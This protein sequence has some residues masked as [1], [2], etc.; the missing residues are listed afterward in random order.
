MSE[1]AETKIT[2]LE[3]VIQEQQ[4]ELIGVQEMLALVLKAVGQDVYVTRET[5][6]EGL[7]AGTQIKVE[8]DFQRNAFVFG[9]EYPDE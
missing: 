1:A 9:L 3:E 5:I 2:E 8:E 7:P 4:R 6:N